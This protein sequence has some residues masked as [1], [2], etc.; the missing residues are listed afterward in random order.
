MV[1]GVE[2]FTVGK[3]SGRLV[4]R[5]ERASIGI[6]L[7]VGDGVYASSATIG[8]DEFEW[9]PGVW[10]IARLLVQEDCRGQG[11]GGFLVTRVQEHLRAREGF[12]KLTV[13]PG[14]YNSDPARQRAFYERHGFREEEA[15][16][17]LVWT[18]SGVSASLGSTSSPPAYP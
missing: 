9:T 8:V 13:A 4:A 12:V 7:F 17:P 6:T 5:V 1:P 2:D 18:S 10:W 14:G 11:L 3:L 15:E 16:G